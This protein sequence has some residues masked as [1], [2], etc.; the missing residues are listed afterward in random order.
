MHIAMCVV[1][2]CCVIVEVP[3]VISLSKDKFDE[4]CFVDHLFRQM[5][6]GLT[7]I[8][9]MCMAARSLVYSTM[10]KCALAIIQIAKAGNWGKSPQN[11]ER[12]V[13]RFAA[14]YFDV[15]LEKYFVPIRV[16]IG[17]QE[18]VIPLAMYPI[19]EFLYMLHE[20]GENKFEEISGSSSVS[21]FWHHVSGQAWFQKHP[22]SKDPGRLPFAIPCTMFGDDARLYKTEKMIVWEVG[23]LLSKHRLSQ[24]VIGAL[25][26]YMANE[27]TYKDV[28]AAILW[29]WDSAHKGIFPVQDHLRRAIQPFHGKRRYEM[30]GKPL[31]P[32]Q[33]KAHMV[34]AGFKADLQYERQTFRFRSYDQHECCRD[35]EG[36]KTNPHRLYTSLEDG[37]CID[38]V[39][40]TEAYIA[41]QGD[42]LSDLCRIPGWDLSLHRYDPM[43][44][45]FLGIA[46]H[47]LGSIL[48]ELTTTA[49]VW[50]GASRKARLLQAWTFWRKHRSM[51][52]G[53]VSA[54][55]VSQYQYHAIPSMFPG[56]SCDSICPQ[57][58]NLCCYL[59]SPRIAMQEWVR[60]H[61]LQCSQP[62][63]TPGSLSQGKRA[64]YAELK[65]KAHNARVMVSWMSE[66]CNDQIHDGHS[67]LRA[68]MCYSLAAWCRTVDS[69]KDWQLSQ[70]IADELY[71]LGYNFLKSYQL[72]SLWALDQQR[73]LYAW[74]PK[75]HYFHH[76]I[77]NTCQ[78]RINPSWLWNYSE[79]DLTGVA[80]DLGSM[81]H[82]SSVSERLLDRYYARLGLALAGRDQA[83]IGRPSWLPVHVA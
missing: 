36:H 78:E 26:H 57:G 17:D 83:P 41:E 12:D 61:G 1:Q 71:K 60:S 67:R 31:Y 62:R 77:R 34:F 39:R 81:T 21:R 24:L 2:C 30:R 19:H 76:M 63:F 38:H 14:K 20:A 44:V 10:G 51:T 5:S 75:F 69:V 66:V 82:R 70:P 33:P 7:S 68:H 56:V 53:G 16:T 45:I 46:L 4:D 9:S 13:H 8:S 55:H 49:G 54:L 29:M 48:M 22:V 73:R 42:R 28:H 43:H 6:Q 23:F 32:R 80:I 18:E 35:C 37:G 3:N 11:V 64:T 58:V 27:N 47:V 74:K 15:A 50:P 59:S 72:L 52:P 40:T 79:E 65:S 25:P